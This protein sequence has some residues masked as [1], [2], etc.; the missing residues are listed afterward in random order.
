MVIISQ[1]IPIHR[2]NYHITHLKLTQYHVIYLH[3]TPQNDLLNLKKKLYTLTKR[4]LRLVQYPKVINVKNY[5]HRIS[6]N[7]THD[8]LHSH[9]HQAFA[10]IQQPF[11]SK[12]PKKK[13][14]SKTPNKTGIE[15]NF[16]NLINTTPLPP[17]PTAVNIIHTL[18]STTGCFSPKSR[19]SQRYLLCYF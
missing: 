13:K 3:K 16:P 12:T 18:W 5:I 17:L 10:E 7:T 8:H 14:K 6:K 9:T 11:K 4:D 2:A 15:G 1:Y 19:T